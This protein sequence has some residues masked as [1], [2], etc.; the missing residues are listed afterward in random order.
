MSKGWKVSDMGASLGVINKTTSLRDRG[1]PHS[2]PQDK[3]I[4]PD[5]PP[6]ATLV[7][8]LSRSLR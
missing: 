1:E 5:A 2:L 8:P 7:T 3:A 6:V 4:L